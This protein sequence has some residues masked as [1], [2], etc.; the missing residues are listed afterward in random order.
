MNATSPLPLDSATR[1]V[2]NPLNVDKLD[3]FELTSSTTPDAQWIGQFFAYGGAGSESS[4]VIYFAMP[5]ANDSA[6]TPTPRKRPNTS[7]AGPANCFW[8]KV[9]NR[10]APAMCL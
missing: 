3:A 7:L 8:M 2:T 10:C 6:D 9:S 4:T 1:G 5:E